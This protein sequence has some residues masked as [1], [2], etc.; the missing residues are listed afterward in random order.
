MATVTEIV[1]EIRYRPRIA[2]ELLRDLLTVQL[3]SFNGVRSESINGERATGDHEPLLIVLTLERDPVFSIV[4]DAPADCDS[5]TRVLWPRWARIASDRLSTPCAVL[6]VT[7]D[8]VIE[9][10]AKQPVHLDGEPPF[11]PFVI[12]PSSI[13]SDGQKTPIIVLMALAAKITQRA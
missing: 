8:P 11:Y 3:P 6:I 1:R 12:G 9:R 13:P 4:V 5:P 10:W 7:I 2:A